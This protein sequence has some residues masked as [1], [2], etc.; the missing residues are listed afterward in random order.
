[1]FL[2]TIIINLHKAKNG[3]YTSVLHCLAVD[4]AMLVTRGSV[5][6]G[7]A[8]DYVSTSVMIGLLKR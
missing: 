4:V 8:Y 5:R 2:I 6:A 1:M 3:T 7:I